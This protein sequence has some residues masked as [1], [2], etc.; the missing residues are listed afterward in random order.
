M[1]DNSRSVSFSLSFALLFLA[2][3]L[4]LSTGVSYAQAG[5]RPAMRGKNPATSY[6]GLLSMAQSDGSVRVIV[7][8]AG[9]F[10]KDA[11]LSKKR[12]TA[13]RNQI[14][15]K[16]D[17]LQKALAGKQVSH[18]KK[19]KHIPFIAMRVDANG[20]AALQANP[21]VESV[22]EDV[23]RFPSLA[24]SIPVIGADT[25]WASGYTGTGWTV[26]ILDTGVDSSHTFLTGK[27]VAEACYSST[28]ARSSVTTVCPNGQSSQTGT[29][30]GANCASGTYGC[31]HGTHVA[32]IAT[33]K[34]TS[35]SGVAKEANVIALQV[36]SSMSSVIDCGGVAYSPCAVA[37]DSDIILA[38]EY[39][40]S[41]RNTYN[42]ASVNM[43]LG[44]GSYTTY[45][46]TSSMKPAIDNLKAVG[47]ATAVASGN[48][49]SST[50]ISSPACISSAVSVGATTD[51]DAVATYSNSASILTLLAPGSA[52]KSSVPGGTYQSWNG[53]SM[54]TPHVAG[55]WAVLKQA[56]STGTVDTLLSTLQTTGKSITDTR[57]SVVVSR[58]DVNAAVTSLAGGGGGGG[59]TNPGYNTVWFMNSA[60]YTESSL[61]A[62]AGTNWNVVGVG[63]FSGDGKDDIFW[64]STAGNTGIWYMNG[65]SYTIQAMPDISTDWS[66]I[67][68]GDF[69]GDGDADLLWHHN[70]MELNGIWLMAGTSYTTSA[71]PS[72]GS[73]WEIVGTGDL[74]GS[75][76]DD[77]IWH[78]TSSDTYGIWW[79]NGTSYTTEAFTG[80]GT[81]WSLAGMG[82]FNADGKSDI[83]WRSTSGAN[84]VW[85]M[86]GSA[87]TAGT[88]TTVATTA[89]PD[90][91]GDFNK[92]GITDILWRTSTT[93][94]NTL[95]F[96]TAATAYTTSTLTSQGTTWILAGTGDFDG[97]GIT[98]L[99]WRE[100]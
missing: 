90:G 2:L 57:N 40:Y 72:T 6:S 14:A 54:A 23:Y 76:A 86:N 66:V 7:K 85:T 35:F 47:I 27:V 18:V 19:F 45:C 8:L 95:W 63:D 50:T 20:L 80:P 21:N 62:V 88:L 34:G 15:E 58:I 87:S 98:D 75:G 59:T 79:M 100:P 91:F 1:K 68:T 71:M 83:L 12:A 9:S 38:L 44:G 64:H 37:Y 16:Q 99:L 94:A 89:S 30:A 73:I 82:D 55:T 96:M 77:L 53:T 93:G 4:L 97:D 10:E 41:L 28:D 69:D 26:A 39:V 32:G 33:G 84:T 52:I 67:S 48:D 43:S 51:A 65:T 11:N 24:S 5:Q 25:A 74:D 13:Q 3:T 56:S 17:A 92:D 81:G 36:F 22:E 61:P 49:Y 31:D 78:N 70:T 46:D 29:G 60:T 42:I